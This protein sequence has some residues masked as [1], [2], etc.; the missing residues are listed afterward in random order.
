MVVEF[1]LKMAIVIIAFGLAI[2]IVGIWVSLFDKSD[3]Y[4]DY[5]HGCKYGM[6]TEEPKRKE[7]Q[8][9]R[10]EIENKNNESSDNQ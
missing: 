2:A 3:S 8:K 5:C 10:D 4:Y 1:V 6:C 7:C 9:W